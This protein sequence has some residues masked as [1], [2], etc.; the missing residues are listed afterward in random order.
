MKEWLKVCDK[1]KLGKRRKL[2]IH[3]RQFTWMSTT[4]KLRLLPLKEKKGIFWHK[5]FLLC[6]HTRYIYL[7]AS[8]VS[9][10]TRNLFKKVKVSNK[11]NQAFIL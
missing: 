11:T 4:E 1:N 10:A 3:N 2:I 7:A 5:K 6:H 9:H 8:E